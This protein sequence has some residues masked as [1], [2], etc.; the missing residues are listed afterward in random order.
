MKSIPFCLKIS[1]KCCILSTEHTSLALLSQSIPNFSS[2]TV[3]TPGNT[4]SV[5]KA[6]YLASYL[7]S[8]AETNQ[9]SVVSLTPSFDSIKESNACYSNK[10][11]TKNLQKQELTNLLLRLLAELHL[12]PHRLQ[13]KQFLLPS[14]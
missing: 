1:C 5:S 2:E 14:T 4:I 9:I 10:N 12:C 7:M 8:A 6:Y 3:C 11:Q 13:L